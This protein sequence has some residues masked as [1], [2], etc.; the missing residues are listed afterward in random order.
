MFIVL[1]HADPMFE[2]HFHG[3]RRLFRGLKIGFSL[4]INGCQLEIFSRM[5]A[6]FYGRITKNITSWK[7]WHFVVGT[8]QRMTSLPRPPHESSA[9]YFWTNSLIS[10]EFWTISGQNKI[11]FAYFSLHRKFLYLVSI[12]RQIFGFSHLVDIL[13]ICRQIMKTVDLLCLNRKSSRRVGIFDL[14][15]P[16]PIGR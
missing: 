8:M 13:D 1:G 5:L 16:S 14:Y 9:L 15:Q 10:S 4:K 11:I 12:F 3:S 6:L 2:E 7:D